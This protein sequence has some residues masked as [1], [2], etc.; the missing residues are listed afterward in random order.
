[1][2]KDKGTKNVKKEPKAAGNKVVSDYQA[3]KSRSGSTEI[4]SS[5]KKK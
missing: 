1:M 2:S 5:G 4:I 3:G